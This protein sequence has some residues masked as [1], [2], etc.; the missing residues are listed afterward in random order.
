MPRVVRRAALLRTIKY[1]QGEKTD[2]GAALGAY[3]AFLSELRRTML[4]ARLNLSLKKSNNNY[5]FNSSQPFFTLSAMNALY[6]SI[7]CFSLEEVRMSRFR[8]SLRLLLKSV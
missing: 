6:I 2:E 3:M 4:L 5:C 7:I 1:W 8:N